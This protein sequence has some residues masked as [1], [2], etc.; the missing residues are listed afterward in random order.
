MTHRT[1]PDTETQPATV[2]AAVDCLLAAADCPY[3]EGPGDGS[4]CIKPAGHDGDHIVTSGVAVMPCNRA[5]LHQPHIPH[6]WWPQP[7]M[8]YVH[9][10]GGASAEE[11]GR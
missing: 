3:G 2:L 8:A 7:G 11:P 4:G 10:P 1:S 5:V 9:C 6:S